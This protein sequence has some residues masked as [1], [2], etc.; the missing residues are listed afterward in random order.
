M[1]AP[2]AAVAAAILIAWLSGRAVRRFGQPAVVGE[3][4][5]GIV[6]GPSVF[7][8]LAPE[9]AGQIFTPASVAAIQWLARAAILVF[10]FLVGLELDTAVLSRHLAGVARIAVISLIVP[11]TIGVLLALWL[12]PTWHGE[13]EQQTAFVLFVGTAM[14]ITALPVLARILADWKLVAT[15]I[16]TFALGCAAI[17]DIVA[18]TMLGVVVGLVRGGSNPMVMMGLAA[19]YVAVLLFGVRPA[20]KRAATWRS[21]AA[22]RAGWLVAVAAMAT[23]SAWVAE[24]LGI[25]AIFGVFLAGVCVP[26]LQDVLEGL[27]R[28]LERASN[29]LQPAF[30]ILIGLKTSVGLLSSAADWTIGAIILAGATVGK[31]GASMLAGRLVGLQWR[32]AFAVGALLNTRGLVTLVALDLGRTLGI[33]SPGLFT[34]FVMMA[35]VTTLATV[36]LLRLAGV[37]PGRART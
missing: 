13:H 26:R 3:L 28:P 33:I 37:M 9:L 36:P 35:L 6:I 31:L 1:A 8:A 12:Y 7:G 18:W 16:G 29:W 27:E 25:H 4:V 11:F 19:I 22:G 21:S 23:G 20:L 10:M 24:W 5:A 34:L 2:F 14:S 32:D 15:T 17:D 30:F